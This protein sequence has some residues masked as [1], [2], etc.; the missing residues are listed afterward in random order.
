M[1]ILAHRGF[2]KQPEEKN[3][4]E[5]FA[6]SFENGFGVETDIRDSL[7][8]LF[9]SHDMATGNEMTTEDF[10]TLHNSYSSSLTLA[11]N[12]KA[13][14][15]QKK[16]AD[17]L[18]KNKITD[19]FFFDMSLPDALGYIKEG[20]TIFSRQ[21]EY[22]K[23]PYLYTEAAGIWLDEFQQHWIDEKV[24]QEHLAKKKKICI[25]S[26]ELHK[27]NYKDEWEHYKY[28]TYKFG[29]ENMMLCTDYP[30]EAKTFFNS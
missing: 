24:I 4:P 22:E 11:L 28:I 21:S 23:E 17:L 19:Y 6:R 7:E 10:F 26:P 30:Q 1:K 8:K 18:R 9:I 25:V 16:M 13:D 27:R 3:R 14:G 15:L 29:L 12:I 20:L 5:A 2:W